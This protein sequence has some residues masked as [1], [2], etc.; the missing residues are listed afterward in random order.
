MSRRGHVRRIPW[1]EARLLGTILLVL[2]LSGAGTPAQGAD[3]NAVLQLKPGADIT[4]TTRG[5]LLAAERRVVATDDDSIVVSNPATPQMPHERIARADVLMVSTVRKR[6]SRIGAAAGVAAGF[7]LG[8]GLAIGIATENPCGSSCR[9]EEMLVGL[10]LV[11]LPTAGGL[12]GYHGFKRTV[13]TV[14]YRIE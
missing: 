2:M 13:P 4:I 6:G 10:S 1:Q 11:G 5:A 14:I 8:Y 3:W 7:L 12:I 9:D